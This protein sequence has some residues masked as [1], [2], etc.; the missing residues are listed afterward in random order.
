M[1]DIIIG[2]SNII[3]TILFLAPMK[4]IILSSKEYESRDSLNS[5]YVFF[6]QYQCQE[7]NSCDLP[8]EYALDVT[9]VLL[10]G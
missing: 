2:W 6:C 3:I 1:E 10:S 7:L 5:G 9:S 8:I 4:Y